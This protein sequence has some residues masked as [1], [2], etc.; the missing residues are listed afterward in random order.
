MKKNLFDKLPEKLPQELF[1]TIAKGKSFRIERIVSAGHS[2]PD[3]FWYDQDQNEWVLLING[4]ATL[5]I[6]SPQASERIDLL[7]G[8]YLLLPAHQRH[9]VVCTDD[10]QKTV[11]LAIHFESE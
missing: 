10:K 9:R 11:W 2:S 7:P 6:E 4:S 3:D 8:D 5:E 1:E